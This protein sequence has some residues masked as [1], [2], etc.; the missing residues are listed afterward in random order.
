MVNEILTTN[1]NTFFSQVRAEKH[2]Q[3]LSRMS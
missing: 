2:S 3:F 1:E